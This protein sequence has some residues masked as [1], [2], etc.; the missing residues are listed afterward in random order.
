MKITIKT[1]DPIIS[2]V[3]IKF[4]IFLNVEV[5]DFLFLDLIHF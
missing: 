2:V 3:S 4:F 1:S 5:T